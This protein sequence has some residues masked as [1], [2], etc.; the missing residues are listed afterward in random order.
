M[1]IFNEQLPE[2]QNSGAQPT[3]TV[4][5]EGWKIKDKP[6]AAWFNWAWH[7]TYMCLKEVRDYIEDVESNKSPVALEIAIASG[8]TYSVSTSQPAT[9]YRNG[10]SLNILT[11]GGSLANMSLNL[12]GLGAKPI[13]AN[14]E[15]LQK[16]SMLDGRVYSLVFVQSMNGGN[17]GWVVVNLINKVEFPPIYNSNLDNLTYSYYCLTNSIT[18][19]VPQTYVADDRFFITAQ[20]NTING[21]IYQTAKSIV[22]FEEFYR[23]ID[24]TGVVQKDWERTFGSSR[25][26]L[27]RNTALFSNGM[28]SGMLITFSA[29]QP[30]NVSVSTGYVYTSTY[31]MIEKRSPET[32]IEMPE[33]SNGVYDIYIDRA[34]NCHIIKNGTSVPSYCI[35]TIGNVTLTNSV[36]SGPV[37]TITKAAIKN[38]A[39]EDM[40]A[41]TIKGRKE[42][43]SGVSQDLTVT[44]VRT[45]I[46]VSDGATK[47][48]ESS[49]NGNIKIDNT[50]T[51]VYTHPEN[52]PPSIITQDASNRF[53]TDTEKSTWNG[54][55]D[56]THTHDDR[57]YTETEV[58]TL[59]DSKVDDSQVLTNVPA[60]AKFTDTIYTHPANHSPSIITQDSSNRFVSDT[61]KS[62]WNSVDQKAEAVNYTTTIP[63]TS[64]TGS[65]APFTKTVTVTGMLSTDTPVID[66]VPTGVYVTD[67][68]I[69]ENWG[70]VYRV[71]TDIDSVT[72]YTH[73]VPAVDIPIV[74]KVVR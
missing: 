66:I 64:W 68:A 19:N 56:G 15:K 61:E 37:R 71:K 24:S 50:E 29:T 39:L 70:L 17:G 27:V 9:E 36:M 1:S 48:E 26:N 4:I 33:T 46:N 47:V 13:F 18:Q 30:Y 55:A 12:D 62:N 40:P 65:E 72:V 73:E 23:V 11:S 54:K 52:H 16:L 74:L 21:F 51:N 45:L 22:T 31:G 63:H 20:V 2:W 3:Q 8:S 41:K 67:V 60:N 43:T 32:A 34:G 42:L 6:P 35:F 53:V 58:N 7:Q 5:D 69:G 57:Y 25:E 10:M 38:E 44:E 28:G 49:T 14:G 59:L